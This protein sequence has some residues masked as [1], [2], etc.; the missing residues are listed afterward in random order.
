MRKEI[1]HFIE[2]FGMAMVTNQIMSNNKS[3]NYSF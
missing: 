3:Y 2:T 1:N